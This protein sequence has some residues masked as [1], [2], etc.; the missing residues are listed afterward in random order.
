MLSFAARLVRW[1]REAGFYALPATAVHEV[2]RR[3]LD[4]I[5]CALGAYD[6]PPAYIAREKAASLSHP[7]G[8]TVLGTAHST[9]AEW[10]AFANGTMVRYLDF[11]DAYLSR[12]AAHPSNNLPAA[13]AVAE[14]MGRSGADMI[15]AAVIGYEIQC[16]LC[17]AAS[18]QPQGWDHPYYSALSTALLSGW[19]MDL[20]EHKLEHA[21]AIAGVANI[22]TRQTRAGQISM[23]KA[24]ACANAARNGV[25]AADLARRGLT[26]PEPL[27]EGPHGVFQQLVDGPFE[28]T[29]GRGDDLMIYKTHL[30]SWPAKL[31]A[32]SAIDAALQ[33]RKSIAG[34][35]ITAIEIA[36]PEAAVRAIGAGPEKQR[37]TSR[38]TAVQSLSYCVAAALIEGN[39]TRDSFTAEK[40]QHPH[41]LALVDKTTIHADPELSAGYP[42]RIPN[43]VKITLADGVVLEQRVDTPRGHASNPLSD[44]EVV[45][46]F[47]RNA[48]GVISSATA[49][50]IIDR[51]WEL[52]EL[53]TPTPLLAFEML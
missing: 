46:K 23:W 41:Y 17:D 39:L 31:H 50:R 20:D 42:Q 38:E 16:R 19:L 43:H 26:G 6:Q 40:R 12:E 24:C 47:R 13:W 7:R 45:A 9:P 35:T 53:D 29:L 52:D 10:A 32:Q 21:L 33:L 8:G 36:S 1:T 25:F 4:S 49:H 2:K 28:I 30:K 18:L 22:P 15:T 27:F 51:C 5:G 37:P 11:N 14:A 44:D 34:R 3:V 48:D